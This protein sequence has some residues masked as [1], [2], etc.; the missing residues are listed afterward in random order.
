MTERWSD[1]E[2]DVGEPGSTVGARWQL[3]SVPEDRARRYR[4]EGWWNDETL[5]ETVARGLGRSAHATF[6][7]RSSVRPWQG[8]FADV[9]RSAR[10]LAGALRA[11]GVGPGD[12]LVF[13]LPNWVE[14]GIT[15]WAAAYLGVVVVPIVHFYG[16]KEV[17]YILRTVSPAVVVTADRFGHN[18]YLA[19]YRELL[20]AHPAARWL[21]I[22]ESS[23]GHLPPGAVPFGSYLDGEPVAGPEPVDPDEP[24]IVG[25]TSGTTRNPKGVVHSHRT[26][27]CETRQL[28]YMFPTGGPP[29][30][31]GAPVGH[32]I[33]MLSAF[34]V[35]LLRDAAVNLI[36]VW[37]PGE[38]LR[39]MRE[40]GLSVGGGA[41]Y[42]LTSLLDHP[43]FTPE[44]LALIPFAGLGGSAVPAAV[45]RRATDLGIKAFR[46]YGSTEHPSITG[47]LLD[48]PE[49]KRLTTDGRAMPGV[50]LRLDDDGQILS[51]GPDCFVGYIDPE[52]TAA[53]FDEDGWYHTGDVGVL[54][55][56]GY[57]TI[58]DR[59][60]DIIIRGGENIS[61][62]EI[63]EL[64]M[65]LTGVAEVC[66][67][68]APD[69]RLGEQAAAVIR[70]REGMATPTIPM[71]RDHLAASGLSRQKWPESLFR[72]DEFP[73]TPSGKVQ[74]FV[75]RQQIR[76]G[77]LTPS[78]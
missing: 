64:M 23:G 27:G 7:V 60:S 74:K 62:A 11:D 40:E 73:R 48:D 34:M 31:T 29:Q 55:D 36:D 59:I 9:D 6:R 22:G 33:G 51:R 54:D 44:H 25:F 61:A 5:G 13:Q 65:G 58:T 26:I 49:V 53:V 8:T 19:T 52:L 4:D 10:A 3:R 37:D 30:I 38:V 2:V 50:E 66:V 43:D 32:F 35:P 17:D 75:L 78:P 15:F 18:D 47:S 20:P 39:M 42:F 45:T 14:A 76:E 63:E 46:S 69:Q 21:V 68:A 41:T 28:N 72:V 77:R 56:D 71:V 70:V 57:L 67:V 24:A 1:E 16:A 12:V